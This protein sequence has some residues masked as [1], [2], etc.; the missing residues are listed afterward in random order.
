MISTI[1]GTITQIGNDYI[2]V[3]VG[4]IGL[5]IAVANAHAHLIGAT[6]VLHMYMH[7]NTEQGPSLYGFESQFEKEVFLLIISC[8]GIGPKI[9]LAVLS[10]LGA[11]GFIGAVHEANEKLLSTV[12]GIGIKKAEQI[13]VQSKHKVQ[14]LLDSGIIVDNAHISK[15]HEVNQTLLSLNYSRTEIQQAME[16]VKS[17]EQQKSFDQMLRVALSY[18]SKQAR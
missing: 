15:L 10:D 12:S 8:S 4:P 5:H 7:W 9:G 13:I 2:F 3:Q 6:I 14:K 17:S 18:L 11:Q 1:Q 16:Y